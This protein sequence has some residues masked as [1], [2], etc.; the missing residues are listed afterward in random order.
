[1]TIEIIGSAGVGKSYY[2]ELIET[3]T[4]FKRIKRFKSSHLEKLTLIIPSMLLAIRFKPQ[5]KHFKYVFDKSTYLLRY[6]KYVENSKESFIMDQ[7]LLYKLRKTSM[8][9]R[10]DTE[11]IIKLVFDKYKIKG[12]DLI[13]YVVAEKSLV[14][15]RRINRGKKIDQNLNKSNYLQGL[16]EISKEYK[17]MVSIQ[18][19]KH[20]T[21]ESKE[22]DVESFLKFFQQLI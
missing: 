14:Y 2:S 8:Y 3:K 19:I 12:P 22:Q 18:S 21:W 20:T 17:S 1:M 7:G 15:K 6:K 9:S 10:L 13:L 16:T 5:K 4:S 11:A